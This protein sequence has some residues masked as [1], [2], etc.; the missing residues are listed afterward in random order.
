MAEEEI[1]NQVEQLQ[2]A[3]HHLEA[4]AR[5][6]SPSPLFILAIGALIGAVVA[7]LTVPRHDNNA[8]TAL[9]AQGGV[10]GEAIAGDQG[11]GTTSGADAATNPGDTSS[12]ASGS[13][14]SGGT[15]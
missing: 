8:A 11:G 12:G 3:V 13:V 9:R 4:R 1:T 7:T 14:D 10:S 2:R 5:R 15:S 6:N